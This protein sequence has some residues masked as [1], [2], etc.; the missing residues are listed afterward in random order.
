MYDVASDKT[1]VGIGAAS[2]VT[3][4]GFNVACRSAP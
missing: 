3:G 2:G 1:V 4:G